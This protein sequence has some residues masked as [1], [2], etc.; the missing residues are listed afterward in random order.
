MTPTSSLDHDDIIALLDQPESDTLEFK[1][2]K[3][4][5]P[6]SLWETYSAMANTKGGTILLG[7]T[8]TGEVHGI[9][10]VAQLEKD[11]WNTINNRTKVNANLLEGDDVV[12]TNH[13]DKAILAIHIPRAEHHQRPVFVGQNPLTGTYQRRF[14][15]D[16]RCTEQEVRNMYADRTEP[17]ADSRILPH[18]TLADLDLDSLHQYR[19][20]FSSHKPNHAWLSEDDQTLLARLGGWRKGRA[21]EGEGLTIAGLLMFGRE[22]TLREGLHKY[23]V[24]YREKLS[25]DPDVR[26]TDRITPDG[27]WPGNLYQFYIRVIQR[28]SKDLSLPFELDDELFRKGETVVHEAIREALVNTLIHADY[29]TDGGIIV[30]KYPDRIELSNPG[31]LLVSREQLS[32]GGVSKC[33]NKTLQTMFMMIGAGE[34]AGSGIDKIHRGWASQN[35]KEPDFDENRELDRVKWTL[36]MVKGIQEESHATPPR[37]TASDKNDPTHFSEQD[38]SANDSTSLIAER[39]YK[40]EWSRKLLRYLSFAVLVLLIIIIVEIIMIPEQAEPE[41]IPNTYYIPPDRYRI[42]EYLSPYLVAEKPVAIETG[43]HIQKSEVTVKDFRPFFESLSKAQQDA[44]PDWNEWGADGPVSNIPWQ[45]ATNYA[46]WLSEKTGYHWRLPD[47]KEWMA[48]LIKINVDPDKAIQ[49]HNAPEDK[50]GNKRPERAGE[51]DSNH[52]F[53]NL[54][55]WS[56]EPC[57]YSEGYLIHGKSYLSD[58]ESKWDNN[59]FSCQSSPDHSLGFRLV[60]E[61]P[62]NG[63]MD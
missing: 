35:W 53:A 11:F 32:Q 51:S 54:R 12:V 19:N 34:K 26:W 6:Q 20:R 60:S 36:P 45:L 58:P 55:E 33:R 25:E 16:Y 3:G 8:D 24:D 29:Q 30:E 43:F 5:L 18:F 56:R 63:T 44:L 14:E 22:D 49:S 17:P 21:N 59:V 46:K 27:T 38:S 28:L 41:P 50:N 39:W 1:S 13:Q 10:D 4:G 62:K 48:A 57:P 42:P 47:K 2:A 40:L 7:V 15:G 61:A 31:C 9:R 52:L 37:K 23:H